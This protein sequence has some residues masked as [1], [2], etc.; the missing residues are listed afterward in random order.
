MKGP[1]LRDVFTSR[2]AEE[3]HHSTGRDA[4]GR[5]L[6]PALVVP[7]TRRQHVVEHVGWRALGIGEG[8]GLDPDVLRLRRAAFHL[9]RLADHH[10][11]GV[12]ALPAS[13]VREL[14]LMLGQVAS[15]AD[16]GR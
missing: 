12:V 1:A 5:Y 10:G 9:V 2:A 7:L 16:T 3:L 4:D 15:R 11:A 8:A 6:D 13:F 14:G